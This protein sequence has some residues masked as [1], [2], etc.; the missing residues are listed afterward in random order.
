[1]PRVYWRSA[2]HFSARHV[3]YTN[4]SCEADTKNKLSAL[5]Y[6]ISCREKSNVVCVWSNNGGCRKEDP[7]SAHFVGMIVEWLLYLEAGEAGL[8]S[9]SNTRGVWRRI[10]EKR[11]VTCSPRRATQAQPRRLPLRG[12][13]TVVASE[14]HFL[15]K[16]SMQT[17]VSMP[18]KRTHQFPAPSFIFTHLLPGHGRR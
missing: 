14:E 5:L 1:M 8:G 11:I 17:R 18:T 10:Q 9:A 16:Q 4:G 15:T 12:A 2:G 6:I 13:A 3:C 7:A